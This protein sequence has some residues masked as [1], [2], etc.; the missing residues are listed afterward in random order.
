MR[1]SHIRV[2][3]NRR[4]IVVMFRIKEARWWHSV[5]MSNHPHFELGSKVHV[6]LVLVFWSE[7]LTYVLLFEFCLLS[8]Y[9]VRQI[10]FIIYIIYIQYTLYTAVQ[11]DKASKGLQ[12]FWFH[13]PKKLEYTVRTKCFCKIKIPYSFSKNNWLKVHSSHILHLRIID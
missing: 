1:I 12:I 2:T 9:K 4:H 11:S 7:K 6:E 5:R 8:S 10:L 13:L 3:W